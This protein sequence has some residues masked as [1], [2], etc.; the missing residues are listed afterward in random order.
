MSKWVGWSALA[1]S[2]VAAGLALTH[3][4]PAEPEVASTDPERPSDADSLALQTLERRVSNLQ[5]NIQSLSSR[6][7]QVERAPVGGDG[8]VAPEHLVREVASLR[9]EL[10]SYSAGTTLETEEGRGAMKQLVRSVQEDL[11]T[12][13]RREW[14][15]QMEKSVNE[16]K[17]EREQRWKKFITDAHLSYEQEQALLTRTRAEDEQR[18]AL[19]EQVAAGTKQFRDVQ[20]DLRALRRQTDEAM[21]KT[22][23]EEQMA[24]YSKLRR[25]ERGGRGQREGGQVR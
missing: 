18:K 17:Q 23:S 25:D 22:L 24:S 7:M 14:Q 2:I 12:E 4:A 10:Q 19:L 1:I 3:S 8:G 21:Q 9:A 16:G 5:Q 13:R 15:Q 11:A 6:L 20:P